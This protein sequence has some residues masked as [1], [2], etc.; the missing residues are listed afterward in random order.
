MKK[1][2]TKMPVSGKIVQTVALKMVKTP[3]LGD[4]AEMARVSKSTVSRVLNR[5][6]KI[7][8]L[9]RERVL[10]AVRELGY[11]PNII[12]RSLTKRKTYTIG[13]L[14]EDILNPFFAEVAKGIE[15]ALKN[16]SYS[17]ILTSSDYGEENELEL[18][19]KFLRY[20]VDG[21]LITPMEP[22]SGA[23]TLLRERGVP[24]FI[25]NASSK[26]KDVSWIESDNFEGGYLAA[27]YLI[28][29]GHR[30]LL[31]LR[32]MK[33]EGTRDRF[34][35]F[36]R[37]VQEAGLSVDAHLVRGD[38]N[39]TK[40]SYA[41]MNTIIDEIGIESLPTGL[42]A[43]NDAVAIGAM[44]SLF[45]RDVRIPEDVSIIGYDDINFAGLVRVPLT[46]I[47]QPKFKMGELAARQLIDQI[48]RKGEG[49]AR[50]FLV[51]P[52]LVVRKSCMEARR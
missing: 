48:E 38:V 41:L 27:K 43:V 33:L 19:R 51:K 42:V 20:R 29:L 22:E 9:T 26:E 30:R 50:Q 35:G 12:A 6:A 45:E 28:G 2:L 49:V 37:A 7:S 47:H 23:I 16:T 8:S 32:S 34:N 39:A 18:A 17:M 4:V 40:D 15:S 1:W 52:S 13:V 44:E 5:S 10:D 14:L 46:T 31:C 21:V 11:E 25:M 24:F 3:T 36:A